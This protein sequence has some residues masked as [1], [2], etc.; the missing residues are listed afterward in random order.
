MRGL[1]QA[2]R[3]LLVTIVI[4]GVAVGACLAALIPGA[5]TVANASYYTSTKLG[6]L[7]ELYQ[8]STVYDSAGNVLAVLG[9][10]NRE[11]IES[12]DEVPAILQ[13]AVIAVEDKTFWDN[14]GIDLHG[15]VR[16][17]I[18]NFTEGGVV[19]GGSTISQQLIKN[20]ILS[21]GHDTQ[22]VKD[23]LP[24]DAIMTVRPCGDDLGECAQMLKIA[25]VQ[26][27]GIILNDR[28]SPPLSV[29]IASSAPGNENVISISLSPPFIHPSAKSSADVSARSLLVHTGSNVSSTT[30]RRPTIR[31]SARWRDVKRHPIPAEEADRPHARAGILHDADRISCA[32]DGES[33]R[34]RIAV[35]GANGDWLCSR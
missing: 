27:A 26:V 5:T 25:D 16:A 10:E 17:L 2:I 22:L 8:R 15:T 21:T 14:N 9:L 3:A 33:R 32:V 1:P 30:S 4:G 28:V 13:N 29:D 20:R 19:Q 35:V 23:Y 11:P 18:K 6:E 7:S 34:N 31:A 12:L 24:T